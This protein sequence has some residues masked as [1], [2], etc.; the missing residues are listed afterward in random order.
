MYTH[1]LIY[2]IMYVPLTILYNIA[3]QQSVLIFGKKVTKKV[4]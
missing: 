3:A 2:V 4:F 1:R